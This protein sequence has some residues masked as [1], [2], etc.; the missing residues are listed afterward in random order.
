M[1]KTRKRPRV[2]SISG[3]KNNIDKMIQTSLGKSRQWSVSE[4]GVDY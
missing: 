4:D 1:L 3:R 2:E